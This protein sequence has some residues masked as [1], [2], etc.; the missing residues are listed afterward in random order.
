MD[1]IDLLCVYFCFVI[2]RPLAQIR[3]CVASGQRPSLSKISG[4]VAASISELMKKCWHQECNNRPTAAGHY[5]NN[6]IVFIMNS[7]TVNEI[8]VKSWR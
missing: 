6:I 3:E 8:S 4:E 1:L 7:S 5:I 2:G